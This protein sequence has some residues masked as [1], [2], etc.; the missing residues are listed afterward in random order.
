M[1]NEMKRYLVSVF[2]ITSLQL[3]AGCGPAAV[4]PTVSPL[5][6]G[7][8]SASPPN[9]PF[10]GGSVSLS[11]NVSGA[12]ELR[13]SNDSGVVTG[14][15]KEVTVEKTTEFVLT[16]TDGIKSV[17]ASVTVVV[18]EKPAPTPEPMPQPQDTTAPSIVS[19]TPTHE[20]KGVSD[21][22]SIVVTFSEPMKKLDTQSAYQSA[23]VGI[24]AADVTF[25]W[26]AEG[27]VLTIKPNNKLT[28]SG[29]STPAAVIAKT[30]TFGLTSVAADLAGNPLPEV[31]SSF[32]TFRVIEAVAIGQPSLSGYVFGNGKYAYTSTERLSLGDNVDNIGHQ[33]FLSF[34]L[35]LDS[36]VSLQDILSA[37]LSV[38]KESETGKPFVAL[39]PPCSGVLCA[40]SVATVVLEHV[41]FGSALAVNDYDTAA[42]SVVGD[43]DRPERIKSDVIFGYESSTDNGW[44]SL[45]VLDAVKDDWSNR[46][47][48]EN[49]S[50]YRLRFARD[51]NGDGVGDSVTFLSGQTGSS[52]PQLRVRYLIP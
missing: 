24:R 6:I 36:A 5:Q 40:F 12:S 10:P 27:T 15:S 38:Y 50:Q 18:A 2:F 23:S 20:Q 31:T 37:T 29:G 4:P 3:L 14:T 52:K 22:A 42:L 8:F 32:S 13:L 44:K 51:T 34:N 11:W 39:K 19:I 43:L 17:Q 41:N 1:E 28:M 16:A 46:L 25:G 48:R 9:L 21:D 26:N 47:K 35:E 30:Y 7:R 33:A 45:E 49:R